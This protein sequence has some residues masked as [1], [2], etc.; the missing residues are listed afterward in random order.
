M[1]QITVT[2]GVGGA[3]GSTANELINQMEPVLLQT[4]MF[5]TAPLESIFMPSAIENAKT[6]Q[7]N[8]IERLPVA[9][10]PTQLVEGVTPDAIGITINK[11]TAT[12]EQYGQPVMISELGQYT[13]KHD[14]VQG[15]F[16]N[17]GVQMGD[18]RHTLLY[19]VA[20]AMTNTFRVND[21]A[22]DAAIQIGDTFD[23]HSLIRVL[24]AL[25]ANGV[26]PF[27]S[28]G[29]YRLVLPTGLYNTL[30]EDP[31]YINLNQFKTPEDIRN[32]YVGT[33][34]NLDIVKSNHFSFVKTVSTTS[35]NSDSVQSGFAV[36]AGAL[37]VT[38]LASADRKLFLDPPGT[39]GNDYLRQRYVMSWKMTFKS[40]VL[41][42]NFCR[43]V[44]ASAVDAA[45]A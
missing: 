27:D 35:G 22:N 41:N 32:G 10:S 8:R 26:P 43:R 42:N 6:K 24:S 23:Y 28:T 25:D 13:A 4:A 18:V 30:L 5:T 17:L 15:A 21:R 31:T 44:R 39:M 14:I 33:I 34:S 40:V 9:A 19:T 45:A 11:V 12:L 36:G 37:G 2:T 29:R 3:V 16:K 20:D 7:W 38:S 1:D